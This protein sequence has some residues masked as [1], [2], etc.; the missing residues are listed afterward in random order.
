[1]M[2]SQGS[3]GTSTAVRSDFSNDPRAWGAKE[4]GQVYSTLRLFQEG[5]P[6]RKLKVQ[7]LMSLSVHY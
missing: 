1:M 3:T 7:T 4:E 6:P 2:T 5:S